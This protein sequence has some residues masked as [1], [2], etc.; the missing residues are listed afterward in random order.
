MNTIETTLQIWDWNRERTL[1]TLDSTAE[2][3]DPQEVLGWRPGPERAHIA[4]Q[5]MH[6]GITEE[7]FATER[8]T[9]SKPDFAD[10]VPRFRGGS[11]PDENIPSVDQIRDLL[12]GSRQHLLATVSGFSEQD[13]KTIS[14]G[15]LDK[16][17][18]TIGKALRV[19]TWHEAHH[20]GQ[21]HITLNLFKAKA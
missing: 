8:F 1:T 15:L 9:G 16:P 11:T 3:G 17:G 4:W 19:I 7:L 21:V 13:L 12:D 6:I 20:Q 5:M 2:F 14:D 18:W 10:L